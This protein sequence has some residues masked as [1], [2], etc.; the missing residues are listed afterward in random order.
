[1]IM[2]MGSP[3][4]FQAPSPTVLDIIVVWHPHDTDGKK[5]YE[6]LFGHY[7]SASFA[8]LAG[9]AIEV[10]GFSESLDGRRGGRPPA[11]GTA[12]GPI[13][14]GRTLPAQASE[15]TMILPFIGRGIIQASMDRDSPWQGYLKAL[16]DAQRS[17]GAQDSR[18]RVLPVIPPQTL[19]YTNAPIIAQ[20]L[21][22]QGLMTGALG[23]LAV[24]DD[25][26]SVAGQG[27]LT[28][29]LGQTLI[30]DLLRDPE[31]DERLQVFVSHSRADIPAADITGI[32]PTG[33]VARVRAI[34]NRTKLKEFVDVNDLQPGQDWIADIRANAQRGAL[35]MVRTDHYASR[36]WTQWE[37]L[38]AKSAD[39]PV[40][41]L[42]AL[43]EGEQ[44]G[45]FLLD[46]VPTVA[47][48][49][50]PRITT[51]ADDDNASPLV[52]EDSS[53][54]E[55]M[56]ESHKDRMIVVALNR[57]VDESLKRAL[58][59][60]QGIPRD[61]VRR[62]TALGRTPSEGNNGNPTTNNDGFDAAPFHAP[63]P[64]MLTHFLTRHRQ[65]FP[66]DNHLWLM[67]PDPPLLPP[68]HKVMV[69]LCALSGYVREHIHF[70]TPRTFFAAGGSYGNGE[71]QLAAS[72]ITARRPLAGFMLGISMALGEDLHAIGLHEG[73]LQLAVG[74]IAQM[75]LLAGG[76]ITYAGALGTHTPDL[77]GAVVDTVQRY[78]I[79]L[80]QELHRQVGTDPYKAV[81]LHEGQMFKLTVPCVSVRDQMTLQ[82]LNQE[83]NRFASTGQIDILGSNGELLPIHQAQ[84]WEGTPE[85]TAAAL[86]AIRK[87]LPEFCHARLL[88]G[89]KTRPH[90]D[91]WPYGYRG[92][93]P[94]IIEE[95]LYTA[96]AGQ[97]LFL[98][99]GF[100]GA[101]AVLAHE[102]GIGT[103]LPVSEEALSAVRT[104]R[105]YREAVEEIKQ[106]YDPSLTGLETTEL[107]RLTHTQRG[108]EMAGLVVRGLVHRAGAQ[109]AADDG[110]TSVED[111]DA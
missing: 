79:S 63:E 54:L 28:R 12:A 6:E 109:A 40:V 27:Q 95:A 62:Y 66:G 76:G 5:I 3:E 80:T 30:Q 86:T 108:S 43:S 103:D 50:Y 7:H 58:W 83:A 56:I 91:A 94:G 39:M 101:T 21:G 41:C 99:G 49:N 60:L 57:I 11:I 38:D 16:L 15:F 46:H 65:M 87:A 4:R 93:Y 44:R 105:Y 82:V 33:P 96:R 29:D 75:M 34:A 69:N 17:S 100:G 1:M 102:L 88:I 19:D 97:P 26:G 22:T 59:R 18:V 61:V 52:E 81:C 13:G 107:Q 48:P 111:S 8:G 25:V 37:V 55:S 72:N 89:G 85:A 45:S 51:V 110:E 92:R 31:T 14:E 106:R 24:N 84:P 36:E 2:V 10:F 47:Y 67:H 64:L 98:A 32:D 9:G 77:T 71:P 68:E 104:I 42:S 74:E 20:L 78:I 70:L 35:L 23:S 90:S 73:H 53:K